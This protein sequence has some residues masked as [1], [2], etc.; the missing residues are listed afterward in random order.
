MTANGHGEIP[1]HLRPPQQQTP[2]VVELRFIGAADLR[3]QT[4]E[5]P[6]WLWKDYIATGS[7]VIPGGKPKAGKST[8]IMAL[9]EAIV[10]GAGSFLGRA[11]KHGKVVYVSEEAAITLRHKLPRTNDLVMLTREGAWPKPTWA[12]LVASAVER[13]KALGAVLLVIDT[14]AYWAQLAPEREQD[15]G[16]TGDAIGKLIGATAAGIA[17]VLVHHQ[18]KGGGE[19]GEGLRGSGAIAGSCDMILEVER[20]EGEVPKTHRQIVALGRWPQT[21]DVLIVDWD[22]ATG[23]WRVIGE[24]DSRH[25]S[26][27]KMW[28]A[29]L[30]ECVI[31][32]PGA[33]I[34]DL[35]ELL[36]SVRKE[37]NQTLQNL[38][39][40]GKIE[41]L[42]LGR[43][44]A[45]YRHYP[46]STEA[47]GEFRGNGPTESHGKPSD[48]VVDSVVD[49]VH[50]TT[51]GNE[52]VSVA[53]EPPRN[54]Q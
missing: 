54:C 36:G 26:G 42:G 39:R 43:K 6:E 44:G 28:A 12:Q 27:P 13:A 15:A 4:P 11:V 14:F 47:V 21:P 41:R 31:R 25:E 23:S 48:S 24:A 33:T 18:R 40:E 30:E 9:S 10:L 8:L 35:E 5:E 49:V 45:P 19:E 52:S 17:V 2:P 16:A 51:H 37:W 34:T 53:E 38:L 29:R 32:N 7:L 3:A 22:Q 20:M 46:A 50:G 1:A